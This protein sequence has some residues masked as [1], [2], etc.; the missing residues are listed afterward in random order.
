M[1]LTIKIL[2]KDFVNAMHDGHDFKLF[3]DG[4][5]LLSDDQFIVFITYQ[6]Q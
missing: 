3:N 4:V 1:K 6:H 5:K 2:L